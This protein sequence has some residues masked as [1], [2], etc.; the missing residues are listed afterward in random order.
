[1]ADLRPSSSL[2][3]LRVAAFTSRV[4]IVLLLLLMLPLSLLALA[5]A[6]PTLSNPAASERVGTL[7]LAYVAFDIASLFLVGLFHVR[8]WPWVFAACVAFVPI[9]MF[10]R[11]AWS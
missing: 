2:V 3:P 8:R 9:I 7:V 6:G 4:A 5:A 11:N 10:T 1:M